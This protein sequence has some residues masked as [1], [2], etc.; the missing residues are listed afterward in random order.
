MYVVCPAID[1]SEAISAATAIAEADR[2]RLGPLRSVRVAVVHGQ[3]RSAERD[4]V[5]RAFQAGEIDVLVTTSLVEVGIDVSGATV[6]IIEGAEHFGL[7]QLHQL[8]GR[9]GR[10]TSK[11]YCL[12]FSQS[13]TGTAQQRLSA[14]LDTTDGF[15]LAERDLEIRGEGQV[16][17]ARQA[18]LPDLKLARLAHDREALSKARRLASELLADDPGL[19][20]DTNA[21]L[22]S[23][24]RRC[25]RERARLAA[26]GLRG[27]PVGAP[28]YW[29]G[30]ALRN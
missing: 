25:L 6:M 11:S 22:R 19:R 12:L 23:R 14:L 27:S 9:V 24:R 4:E 2:L 3:L 10:G 13:E 20:R 1:E 15:V 29:L 18:G 16:M 7:A 5:M 21:P 30:C 17:G 26:Q 28:L 8:R